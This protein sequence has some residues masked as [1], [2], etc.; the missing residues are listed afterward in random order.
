ME[1]PNGPGGHIDGLDDG[2]VVIGLHPVGSTAWTIPLKARV[3]ELD[4]IATSHK[5][6]LGDFIPT[7]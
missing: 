5:P 3:T 4:D 7:I 2:R 6:Q 1:N